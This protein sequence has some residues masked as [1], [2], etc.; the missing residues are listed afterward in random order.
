MFGQTAHVLDRTSQIEGNS[1]PRNMEHRRSKAIPGREMP[2]F[3]IK[4]RKS[5]AIPGREMFGHKA[6]ILDRTSQIKGNSWPQNIEHRKSKAIP[7]RE[8]FGHKAHI[9]DRT[10]QME[11]NS[12]PRNI[13]HRRSKA[14]PDREISNIADRRQFQAAKC[15]AIRAIY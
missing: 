8:M 1:W 14:I 9:L 7:G 5:K 13:E 4:H 15:S 3:K 6:H 11:G 10:S 12:W 2:I